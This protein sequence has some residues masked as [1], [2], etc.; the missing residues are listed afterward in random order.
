MEK[1]DLAKL[2]GGVITRADTGPDGGLVLS[3]SHDAGHY[4]VEARACQ[5]GKPCDLTHIEI[6][7]ISGYGQ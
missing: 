6:T 7:K 4:V 1:S 3:I 5:C 2:I